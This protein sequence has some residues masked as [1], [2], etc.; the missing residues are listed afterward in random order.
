MKTPDTG[1]I[2]TFVYI[3]GALL[4]LFLVYKILAG[5][6]LIKT[7]KRKAKEKTQEQAEKELRTAEYFDTTLLN[8][9]PL[10]SPLP[11]AKEM[12]KEL[13]KSLRGLGT[14]E[15]KIFSIFGRLKNKLNISEI[16]LYYKKEYKNDLGTDILNDMTDK[17]QVTL[18]QIISKL[19]AR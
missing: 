7:A 10:Y 8:K 2:L 14:D 13:R 6:G 3:A 12:A 16:A 19:P 1:K 17:E 11:G 5:I 15:E 18:F 4:A 9:Y